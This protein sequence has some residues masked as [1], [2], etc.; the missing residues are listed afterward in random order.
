MLRKLILVVALALSFVLIFTSE[1][2]LLFCIIT[3]LLLCACFAFPIQYAS[4]DEVKM[5]ARSPLRWFAS[6][7][8][9]LVFILGLLAFWWF[10]H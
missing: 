9:Y 4:R 1:H 2:P 7:F 5:E 10:R 6:P 3:A 8:P